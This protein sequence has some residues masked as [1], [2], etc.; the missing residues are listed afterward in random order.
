MSLKRIV[1]SPVS[2]AS[3]TLSRSSLET[4]LHSAGSVLRVLTM[5]LSVSP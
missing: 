1:D 2:S 3:S 5:M 4:R